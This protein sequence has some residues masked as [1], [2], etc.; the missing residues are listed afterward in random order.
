M[1]CL[2]VGLRMGRSKGGEVMG[3]DRAYPPLK[4]KRCPLLNVVCRKDCAFLSP[5][6]GCCAVLSLASSALELKHELARLREPAFK[7][8][9][10]SLVRKALGGGWIRRLWWRVRDAWRVLWGRAVANDGGR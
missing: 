8:A 10:A 6:S 9:P 4:P 2:S 5:V 7:P 1:R 3:W